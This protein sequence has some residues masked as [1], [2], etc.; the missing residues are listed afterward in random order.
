MVN[1]S[2]P[3]TVVD[4]PTALTSQGNVN[5]VGVVVDVFQTVYKTAGSPCITFTLKSDNL[6]NGHVWDGLKV[7]YFKANESQLPPVREGDI[8]KYNGKPLGVAADNNHIPWAIFRSDPDPLC[9]NAP[10]C[11][12]TPFEPSYWETRRCKTLLDSTS[13]IKRFRDLSQPAAFHS[14]TVQASASKQNYQTPRKFSLIKDLRE[15]TYVDLVGEVVKIYPQNSEKVL[16]YLSDYTTNN[17]LP[18]HTPADD[19]PENSSFYYR[20]RKKWTGPSGQM[21]LPVTLWEPHASFAREQVTNNDI[22]SLTLVHIKGNRINTTLEAS[23]H[24]SR[25]NN[26][27]IVDVEKNELAKELLRRKKIYWDNN[28]RKR[29][30]DEIIKPAKGL[31]TRNKKRLEAKKEESEISRQLKERNRP[32]EHVTAS[33]QEV[34]YRSIE[35]IITSDFHDIESQDGIKYRLPFQNHCYKA[36]VRVVDFFPPNLEDFAV[37]QEPEDNHS[38][39]GMDY[40][41]G[42]SSTK[43]EWRFCLLVEDASP[44]PPGQPKEQMKLFVSGSEAEYLLYL[45]A[46]DLRKDS[47]SLAN[48]RERLFIL[49]GD[50]EEPNSTLS[51]LSLMQ[52]DDDNCIYQVT[53]S[54]SLARMYNLVELILE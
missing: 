31:K 5:V 40:A 25:Y 8:R 34:R 36:T 2:S 4:I 53:I 27:R 28:S 13:G 17:R 42:E 7:K 21:C 44:P 9:T 50:L 41:E 37:P 15:Q 51:L 32:N 54:L 29:K 35:D 43:W 3:S 39:G 45:S 18:D 47:R 38:D 48:L 24:S 22:V 19:D 14:F 46:T 23:M 52:P 49:W 33:Y 11:G 20:S 12:P 6:N 10:I 26:V 1:G 30:A 16:L